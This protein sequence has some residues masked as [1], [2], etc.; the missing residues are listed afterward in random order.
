MKPTMSFCQ[1]FIF[2]SN[3]GSDMKP[4]PTLYKIPE[5][6]NLGTSST[7]GNPERKRKPSM[8]LETNAG[9]L[10]ELPFPITH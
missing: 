3:N 2:P 7:N 9:N 10:E 6:Q 4:I 5:S 8:Q 1:E